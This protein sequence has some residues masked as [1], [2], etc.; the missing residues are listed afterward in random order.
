M[1]TRKTT[2]LRGLLVGLLALCT[3]GS[4]AVAITAA[5]GATSPAQAAQA[6]IVA[7]DSPPGTSAHHGDDHHGSHE[8]G[9]H[10]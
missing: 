6:I 10:R 7:L 5:N 3:F 8:R 9:R 2:P 4:S 1:R